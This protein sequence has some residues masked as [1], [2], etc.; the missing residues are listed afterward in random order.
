MSSEHIRRQSPGAEFIS[1]AKLD[2]FELS[3]P[4]WSN[5]WEGGVAD[6]RPEETSHV[7]GM[8]KGP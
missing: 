5:E 7:W 4:R 3:M 6:I 8:F 2:G 1:I